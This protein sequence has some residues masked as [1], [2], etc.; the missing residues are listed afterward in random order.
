MQEERPGDR[1]VHEI[2]ILE[3]PN[4]SGFWCCAER[5]AAFNGMNQMTP[6]VLVARTPILICV[7]NSEVPVAFQTLYRAHFAGDTVK[8]VSLVA[9]DRR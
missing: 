6:R 3:V 8:F 9:L 7:E 2:V 4:N 5:L 1:R